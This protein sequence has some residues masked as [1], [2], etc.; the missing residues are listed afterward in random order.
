MVKTRVIISSDSGIEAIPGASVVSILPDEI[1]FSP[2]EVYRSAMELDFHAFNLRLKLDQNAKP[3]IKGCSEEKLRDILEDLIL[4]GYERFY[5]ILSPA[6]TSYYKPFIEKFISE[7]K[8]TQSY[9]FITKSEGYPVCYMAM[10]AQRMFDAKWTIP[11]IEKALNF[12]DSNNTTYLY[13]P[14]EDKPPR[15]ERYANDDEAFEIKGKGSMLYFLK[16]NDTSMIHLKEKNKSI[17]TYIDVLLIE[18]DGKKVIPFVIYTN[19]FSKC[20]QAF[21]KELKKSFVNTK[22]P[23]Y[24]MSP[25][26]VLK[27]GKYSVAIGYIIRYEKEV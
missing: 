21:F 7:N 15:V 25:T 24:E 9:Y 12:Y 19:Q 26:M 10:E 4:D 22:I 20:T 1:R 18:M 13:S 11:S 14:S 27:Y 2:V 8:K 5:F 17:A 16:K 23:A 6:K 3:E